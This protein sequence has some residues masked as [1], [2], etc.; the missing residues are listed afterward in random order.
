AMEEIYA[1]GK[2]PIIAGGTGFYI[3]SILYDVEFDVEENDKSYRHSL[4]EKAA[5]EGVSVIHKMLEEVDPKAAF[6]IHENNLKR[7]IR[8]LEY[9]HETGKRI[10][11]HNEEQKAKSSPYNYKYYVLNMDREKL[12]ERINLRVDIMLKNGLVEEV[13]NLKDMGYDSDL[14]SMQGIGYKEIRQHIDGELAYDD[15]VEMLKK[16]TRN[17]AKRQ[18]TWFRREPE[19]VWLNHEDFGGDKDKIL[20]FMLDDIHKNIL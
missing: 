18:L 6:E 10:S 11:E 13:K 19:V 1:K 17:F 20:A 14:V 15:A 3:Q 4:E 2:I 9:Y 8:A 7:V 5:V 12:Y 16:N